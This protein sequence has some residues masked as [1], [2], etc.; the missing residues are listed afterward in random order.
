MRSRTQRYLLRHVAGLGFRLTASCM[1]ATA[2][3]M[4]LRVPA[5]QDYTPYS[6]GVTRKGHWEIHRRARLWNYCLNCSVCVVQPV[7]KRGP[8]NKPMKLAARSF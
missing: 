3:Q 8:P 5:P 6:C 2:L 4:T 1:S 7:V